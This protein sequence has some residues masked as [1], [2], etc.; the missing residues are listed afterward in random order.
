MSTSDIAQRYSAALFEIAKEE[1]NYEKYYEDLKRFS[2]ILEENI[3]IS[4]YLNRS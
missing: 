3:C 4:V 2:A 1:E